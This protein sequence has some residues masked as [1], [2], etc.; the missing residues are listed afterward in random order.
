MRPVIYSLLVK[1][2]DN[3]GTSSSSDI[4]LIRPYKSGRIVL[5]VTST[6]HVEVYINL[7]ACIN[8][9]LLDIGDFTVYRLL[10]KLRNK[11]ISDT[12]CSDAWSQKFFQRVSKRS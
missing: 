8:A 10:M 2:H 12:I 7:G 5:A 3:V 11:N 4:C 1:Y 9:G 6:T